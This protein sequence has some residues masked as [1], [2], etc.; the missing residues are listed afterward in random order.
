IQSI[1][2]ASSLDVVLSRMTKTPSGLYY[3]DIVVGTGPVIHGTVDV[4]VHY[5]GWLTN[6]VKFDS[7][8]EDDAPLTVP[9]GRGRAIKGWDIG[10]EGMRV[11]GR[12]QL[13]VPPELAYGSNRAGLIPPDAT[14][15]F[16]LKVVSVK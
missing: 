4:R 1:P 11:G 8:G 2:F 3:R 13:V 10:L 14:L 15:V 6:G 16:D 7:N 9:L 12:R 5:T